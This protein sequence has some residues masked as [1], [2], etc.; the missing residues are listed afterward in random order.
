MLWELNAEHLEWGLAHSKLTINSA[1]A[2]ATI[3]V[4]TT[5]FSHHKGPQQFPLVPKIQ[6][7]LLA[8]AV[9]PVPSASPLYQPHVSP[10]LHSSPPPV[11][12]SAHH[13]SQWAIVFQPHTCPPHCSQ[14]W[15]RALGHTS[16]CQLHPETDHQGA[17]QRECGLGV[18]G[19]PASCSCQWCL[20]EGP[21]LCLQQLTKPLAFLVLPEPASRHLGKGP[22]TRTSGG[23][24]LRGLASLQPGPLFPPTCL[25]SLCIMQPLVLG[26]LSILV[27]FLCFPDK[28]FAYV[29]PL[30]R[31]VFSSLPPSPTSAPG[32]AAESSFRYWLKALSG[33]PI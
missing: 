19:S 12:P 9:R 31:T 13:E 5:D 30:A 7:K 22:I 28:A 20:D 23:T 11:Y 33:L 18:C 1:S 8:V 29:T 17:G 15:P 27:C 14:C 3:T 26:D 24:I 6:H 16:A 32:L 25:L 10:A 4:I 2:A 21:S